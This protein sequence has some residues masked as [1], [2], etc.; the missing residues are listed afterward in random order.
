MEQCEHWLGS[1]R[2]RY[3]GIGPCRDAWFSMMPEV[4]SFPTKPE[5]TKLPY[6]Y[7]PSRMV[8]PRSGQPVDEEGLKFAGSGTPLLTGFQNRDTTKLR[9]S[10]SRC[11]LPSSHIAPQSVSRPHFPAVDSIFRP[12]VA[13][14]LNT[15]H[16]LI[17]QH[18]GNKELPQPHGPW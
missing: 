9:Y 1:Y 3:P 13:S 4:P 10:P 17:F 18:A 7:P 5:V 2:T 11:Q 15:H 6:A 16:G 8:Y 14:L 12:E